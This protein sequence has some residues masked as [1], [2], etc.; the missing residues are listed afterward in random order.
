MRQDELGVPGFES[1]AR[2]DVTHGSGMEPHVAGRSGPRHLAENLIRE[3]ADDLDSSY[4]ARR[5]EYRSRFIT[6]V[7]H[8]TLVPRCALTLRLWL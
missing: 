7:C 4:P 2:A 5:P 8:G 6:L 3:H 1:A